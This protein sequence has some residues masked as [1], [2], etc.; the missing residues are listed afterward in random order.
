MPFACLVLRETYRKECG[1]VV[2]VSDVWIIINGTGK[3]G[4]FRSHGGSKANM[5]NSRRGY[6]CMIIGDECMANNSA[7]SKRYYCLAASLG[8][9]EA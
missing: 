7:T 4:R 2:D 1:I 5:G 3:G 8:Y 9:G 6:W